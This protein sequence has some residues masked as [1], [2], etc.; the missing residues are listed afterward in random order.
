[1]D[2]PLKI[3][4]LGTA[5]IESPR[6]VEFPRHQHT[7]HELIIVEKGDYHCVINDEEMTLRPLTLAL[8][9]P[10]DWHRDFCDPPARYLGLRL[11]LLSGGSPE[12]V[13]LL[14]NGL[15]AARHCLELDES[16]FSPLIAG[17]LAERAANDM[18]SKMTLDPFFTALFWLFAR[19]FRFEDLTGEV[20]RALESNE[21][22]PRLSRRLADL[23]EAHISRPLSVAEMARSLGMSES[24]LAHRCKEELGVPPSAAFT[25]HKMLK[26]RDFLGR[27]RMTIKEVGDFL[28]FKNPYHF[29]KVFKRVHGTP[30]GAVRARSI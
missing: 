27:S 12:A 6:R 8:L 5:V 15:P 17:A 2:A 13:R 20:R 29:A 25:R 9:N 28:G 30:P 7:D 19:Q 23:F 24:S 18:F 11:K 10:G 21:P 22:S 4:C 3:R 14:R 16:V 1:M 26:A